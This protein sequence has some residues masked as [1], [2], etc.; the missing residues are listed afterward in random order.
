M[1]GDELYSEMRK[2]NVFSY[3]EKDDCIRFQ[4]IAHKTSAK[5]LQEN[6]KKWYFF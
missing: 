4:S 1:L 2:S 3:C 5:K 6:I